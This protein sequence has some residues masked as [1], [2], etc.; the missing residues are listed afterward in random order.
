MVLLRL[1]RQF[2]KSS[3]DHMPG[4]SQARYLDILTSQCGF[5]SGRSVRQLPT[6]VIILLAED[7][8]GVSNSTLR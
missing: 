5:A 4:Q 7:L 2:A 8:L 3:T 1:Q 6:K